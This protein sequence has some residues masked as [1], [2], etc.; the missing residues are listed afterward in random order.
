[1]DSPII[2]PA[3]Q[4]AAEPD[5][6]VGDKEITHLT[7]LSSTTQWRLEKKGL[8]PKKYNLTPNGSRRGRKLS[9]ILAWMDS[10]DIAQAA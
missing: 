8:F 1:M 6:F 2:Q 10:R 7:G 5:R 4:P 9:E 3:Q